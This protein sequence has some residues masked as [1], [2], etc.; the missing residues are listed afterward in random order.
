MDAGARKAVAS[1]Q[2]DAKIGCMESG[3]R[4]AN[5]LIPAHKGQGRG[6]GMTGVGGADHKFVQHEVQGEIG[7]KPGLDVLFEQAI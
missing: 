3:G 4:A 1:V 2:W 6:R 7:R 5:H